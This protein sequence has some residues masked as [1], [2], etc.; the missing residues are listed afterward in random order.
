[1]DPYK[2]R[3]D[4]ME[5]MLLEQLEAQ[6]HN[7]GMCDSETSRNDTGDN[8]SVPSERSDQKECDHVSIPETD[9]DGDNVTTR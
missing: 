4:V 5:K 1:M 3:Q 6:S 9:S 7:S 8:E 2:A